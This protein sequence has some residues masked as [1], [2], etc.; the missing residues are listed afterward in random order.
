M[1]FISNLRIGV[2]LGAGFGIVIVAALFI[3]VFGRMSLGSIQ[4]NVVDLSGALEKVDV[5][6]DINDDINLIARGLRNMIL[7]TDAPRIAA[8]KTRVL[9]ARK[10]V[11]DNMQKLD[12]AITSDKGRGLLKTLTDKRAS[13]SR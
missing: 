8:E 13:T 11:A 1:N 9:D 7:L 4:T 5:V 3:A 2:R 6:R 10:R 12:A